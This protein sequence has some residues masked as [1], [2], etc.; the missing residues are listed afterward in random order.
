MSTACFIAHNTVYTEN[1]VFIKRET[2]NGFGKSHVRQ[3]LEGQSLPG[4]LREVLGII[5]NHCTKIIPI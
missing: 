2:R 5:I 1:T 4:V 3:L